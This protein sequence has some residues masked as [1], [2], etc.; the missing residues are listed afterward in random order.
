[1]PPELK[2]DAAFTSLTVGTRIEG[3]S[4]VQNL[5]DALEGQTVA[6]SRWLME[7]ESVIALLIAPDGFIPARNRAAERV[8]PPGGSTFGS[9]SCVP[10]ANCAGEFQ[11]P[12]MGALAGCC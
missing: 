12:K 2:L 11:I 10:R 4:G 9:T 3:P 8:F 1:M 5:S 7:S 6:L